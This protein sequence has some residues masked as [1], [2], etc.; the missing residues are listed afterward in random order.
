MKLKLQV[1]LIP[2]ALSNVNTEKVTS[3]KKFLHLADPQSTIGE[4]CDALV[5]RYYKLYP[6]DKQLRVEGVQDNDR[7]D[8]DP[9]FCAADVFLS[10]DTLRILCE[11]LLE[12]P[13]SSML[14]GAYESWLPDSTALLVVRKRTVLPEL[15]SEDKSY[16]K[17]SRTIWGVRLASLLFVR[18]DSTREELFAKEGTR[19]NLNLSSSEASVLRDDSLREVPRHTQLGWAADDSRLNLPAIRAH[20]DPKGKRNPIAL[21]TD[22]T[23]DSVVHVSQAK[24]PLLL[25]PPERENTTARI[26]LRKRSSPTPYPGKR[27]TSGM[28]LAPRASASAAPNSAPGSSST[29]ASTPATARASARRS[30][31]LNASVVNTT[32]PSSHVF[33]TATIKESFSDNDDSVANPIPS[34]FSIISKQPDPL[35]SEVEEIDSAS[36]TGSELFMP[37]DASHS[38]VDLPPSSAAAHGITPSKKSPLVSLTPAP[39]KSRLVLPQQNALLSSEPENQQPALSS[40]IFPRKGFFPSRMNSNMSLDLHSGAKDSALMVTSKQDNYSRP[41]PVV[42]ASTP[43]TVCFVP[44]TVTAVNI[45]VATQN[46]APV[47]EVVSQ[48]N[49][50]GPAPVEPRPTHTNAVTNIASGP[51]PSSATGNVVVSESTDVYPGIVDGSPA[52]TASPRF[53]HLNKDNSRPLSSHSPAQAPSAQTPPLPGHAHLSI[54]SLSEQSSDTPTAASVP[55]PPRSQPLTP[56]EGKANS[57]AGQAN[58][59]PRTNASDVS[60]SIA[61]A[62]QQPNVAENYP[63]HQVQ[64]V[65]RG[66]PPQNGRDYVVRRVSVIQSSTVN[67]HLVP[68]GQLSHSAQQSYPDQN[69]LAAHSSSRQTYTSSQQTVSGLQKPQQKEQ[70]SHPV[71][72]YQPVQ[73]AYLRSQRDRSEESAPRPTLPQ[74]AQSAFRYAFF[75]NDPDVR[76]STQP[77][78]ATA[79]A[80]SASAGNFASLRLSELPTSLRELPAVQVPNR[81]RSGNDA[82]NEMIHDLSL[83]YPPFSLGY[84]RGVPPKGSFLSAHAL[85]PP[86]QQPQSR[87]GQPHWQNRGHPQNQYL[88]HQMSQQGHSVQVQNIE[89]QATQPAQPPVQPQQGQS[90]PEPHSSDQLVQP[91]SSSTPQKDGRFALENILAHT[92]VRITEEMET[93]GKNF[94]EVVRRSK[95]TQNTKQKP[96]LDSVA[97]RVA[98][99]S[100]QN[101][102]PNKATSIIQNTLKLQNQEP[103]VYVV[104]LPQQVPKRAPSIRTSTL[105]APKPAE[106]SKSRASSVPVIGQIEP[107]PVPTGVSLQRV[108]NY[109]NQSV[110]F[111]SING[112]VGSDRVTSASTNVAK[113]ID[114]VTSKATVPTASAFAAGSVSASHVNTSV[115]APVPAAT[116][117]ALVT[118][119][120][121]ETA[122]ISSEVSMVASKPAIA[123]SKAPVVAAAQASLLRPK[124][125][126]APIASY[127]VVRVSPEPNAQSKNSPSK[128]TVRNDAKKKSAH[129]SKDEI[130]SLFKGRMRVPNKINQKLAI[131]EPASKQIEQAELERKNIIRMEANLAQTAQELDNRRRAATTA[132]QPSTERSLRSRVNIGGIQ[133]FDI[134]KDS[135]VDDARERERDERA[136]GLPY[137]FCEFAAKSKLSAIYIKMKKFEAKLAKEEAKRQTLKIKS[138][139]GTPEALRGRPKK[140]APPEPRASEHLVAQENTLPRA[141]GASSSETSW[142]RPLLSDHNQM[143]SEESETSPAPEEPSELVTTFSDSGSDYCASLT[144]IAKSPESYVSATEASPSLEEVTSDDSEPISLRTKRPGSAFSRLAPKKRS[145]SAY[146]KRLAKQFEEAEIISVESS[147]SE[148]SAA[149]EKTA[150]ANGK[151][152]AQ[153]QKERNVNVSR[154]VDSPSGPVMSPVPSEAPAPS[155]VSSDPSAPSV[156]S[157]SLGPYKAP[158]ELPRAPAETKSK[159]PRNTPVHCPPGDPVSAP[160]ITLINI[161]EELSEEER[162]SEVV[163]KKSAPKKVEVPKISK[164]STEKKQVTVRSPR[165]ASQSQTQL[166]IPD[167]TKDSGLQPLMLLASSVDASS[168]LIQDS[169][170]AE[171]SQDKAATVEKIPA[172]KVRTENNQA[173]KTIPNEPVQEQTQVW[174][175]PQI[176]DALP[177]SL[178]AERA[179]QQQKVL[180]KDLHEKESLKVPRKELA[181]PKKAQKT[182]QEKA[183]Q[184][185]LPQIE[186]PPKDFQTP[187]KGPGNEAWPAAQVLRANEVSMTENPPKQANED[188]EKTQLKQAPMPQKPEAEPALKPKP[189]PPLNPETKSVLTPSNP[190]PK[191]FLK[192]FGSTVPKPILSP[193]VTLQV[194]EPT[195]KEHLPDAKA[196]SSQLNEN[197]AKHTAETLPSNKSVNTA[198][199]QTPQTHT[200]KRAN[201]DSS[202]FIT[203][204]VEKNISASQSP[205]KNSSQPSLAKEDATN[206]S[207]KVTDLPKKTDDSPKTDHS[208]ETDDSPKVTDNI[209]KKVADTSNKATTPTPEKASDAPKKAIADTPN[210]VH[211][212][213]KAAVDTPKKLK[214]S[215]PETPKKTPASTAKSPYKSALDTNRQSSLVVTNRIA[216]E[217]MTTLSQRA[218]QKSAEVVAGAKIS[219]SF[220]AMDSGQNDETGAQTGAKEVVESNSQSADLQNVVSKAEE[221]KVEKAKAKRERLQR[222]K[223]AKRLRKE[224]ERKEREERE[225]Q[226]REELERKGETEEPK[227]LKQEK[228]AKIKKK[229]KKAKEVDS[230]SEKQTVEE[231]SLSKDSLNSLTIDTATK[232]APS[233]KESPSNSDASGKKDVPSKTDVSPKTD[234]PSKIDT[235]ANKN[236]TPAADTPSEKAVSSKSDLSLKK[237]ASEKDASAKIDS[238]KSDSTSSKE[239]TQSSNDGQKTSQETPKKLESIKPTKDSQSPTPLAQVNHVSSKTPSTPAKSESSSLASKEKSGQTSTSAREVLAESIK[240]ILK[241]TKGPEPEAALSPTTSLALKK[242]ARRLLPKRLALSSKASNKSIEPLELL[243]AQATVNSDDQSQKASPGKPKEQAAPIKKPS[244]PSLLSLTS[245][246]ARGVPEVQDKLHKPAGPI[247][248]PSIS[249]IEPDSLDESESDSDSGSSSSGS[250]S[251][252]NINSKFVNLNNLRGENGKKKKKKNSGFSSLMGDV[253]RR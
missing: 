118:A 222:K 154:P 19:L 188:V 100:N 3:Y 228:K 210:M 73:T 241:E 32:V 132:A 199:L 204:I 156:P 31:N 40:G 36:D 159:P 124:A 153:K 211:T 55:G 213:R 189:K 85:P 214:V 101:A 62:T 238:A 93:H 150:S 149:T 131:P 201:D 105:S 216:S 167:S 184:K 246:A 29:R 10:G 135:A 140:V 57:A 231:L 53:G 21:T 163:K 71:Q 88:Q 244:K 56:A 239:A 63:H 173:E 116:A 109:P 133:H 111:A 147:D 34:D 251:D 95:K 94:S 202:S 27:I 119:K 6:D 195:S 24:L 92:P 212:P 59:A 136:K 11:N 151:E 227:E 166:V 175:E 87:S 20:K 169:R 123:L 130:I 96:A 112:P 117:P 128:E 47:P 69:L 42:S 161:S 192:L 236:L 232:D 1:V 200:V 191:S 224:K 49:I 14:E 160:E 102:A 209:S 165:R 51:V 157:N 80:S 58:A 219:G 99:I 229:P 126:T 247:S 138:E 38:T 127:P 50:S 198:S 225:E 177:K 205:L 252:D 218:S 45:P 68:S 183:P 5:T 44:K 110:N 143:A 16:I 139:P 103:E 23:V 106:L 223:A 142:P 54:Q 253:R 18:A 206:M 28:L 226:E 180:Q 70:Q 235:S 46:T 122:S 203:P 174:K 152:S 89:K 162:D 37:N 243:R 197:S 61:H 66:L 215:K 39:M 176:Q 26:L 30:A 158:I 84:S 129:L 181:L 81:P 13:G 52:A 41:V 187:Q 35:S 171:A 75:Q 43:S 248:K 107:S 97:Q 82:L 185:E 250:D 237:D 91:Q 178:Q 86:G 33:N 242:S 98:P 120:F 145:R 217:I 48:D 72:Q 25:P 9:D 74:P 79:A 170:A 108:V 2:A 146:R 78:K 90:A 194:P 190:K 125:P 83:L 234:E 220:V 230:V 67:P 114:S 121:R 155:K 182:T 137:P 12:H 4:V 233:K 186:C 240:D 113:S 77:G 245:L 15:D 8:L 193:V 144:P 208:P 168:V 249:A 22:T 115:A 164:A 179:S 148:V 134:N 65:T 221:E 104:T 76:L 7:C 17:R 141:G 196:L 172:E 207:K 64:D 60:T